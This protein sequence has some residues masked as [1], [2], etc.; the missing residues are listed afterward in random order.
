MKR[1]NLFYCALF[2]ALFSVCR[3]NA[4]TAVYLFEDFESGTM[5][6]GWSNSG[7]NA[8]YDS[9]RW[10]VAQGDSYN[11][12]Y[13]GNYCMR[14][15]SNST[16][17]GTTSVL[18]SPSVLISYSN[19]VVSFYVR[20]EYGG[21]LKVY[22][23]TDSGRTYLS[24]PLDTNLTQIMGWQKKTYS[25]DQYVGQSV[26]VVFVSESNNSGNY[27]GG[28][29]DIDDFKMYEVPACRKVKDIQ[30]LEATT[31]S[32]TLMWSLDDEGLNIPSSFEFDFEDVSTGYNITNIMSTQGETYG[33]FTM[34]NLES[35]VTYRVSAVGNCFTNG[36]SERS[37]YYYFK[38]ACGRAYLPVKYNFDDLDSLNQIC[39]DVVS[40]DESNILDSTIYYGASGKS[41]RLTSNNSNTVLFASDK[42][43]NSNNSILADFMI[44]GSQANMQYSVG[45]IT[46]INDLSTFEALYSGTIYQSNTWENKH[47][48]LTTSRYSVY[49][50]RLCIMH[51][52]G[53]DYINLDSVLVSYVPSCKRPDTLIVNSIDSV[54][55]T[56]SWYDR[57]TPSQYQVECVNTNDNI[58]SSSI[59][60]SNPGIVNNL[61]P[62]TN[63]RFRVRAICAQGDTSVWS[64][65]VS[66]TT[67]CGYAQLP[68]F[69]NFTD[70][71]S[72]PECWST[73]RTATAP[74]TYYAGWEI[75]NYYGIDSYCVKSPSSSNGNRY[76]LTLPAVYIPT[77]NSYELDFWF[78][79]LEGSK[80]GDCVRIYVNDK[81]SLDG[82]TFIDSVHHYTNNYPVETEGEKYYEYYFTIPMSGT[83]YVMIES[84]HRNWGG[85][86]FIDNISVAPVVT[87]RNKV[88]NVALNHNEDNDSIL[89]S[90]QT[91]GAEQQWLVS[92]AVKDLAQDT[93]AYQVQNIVVNDSVWS[94]DV[95]GLLSTSTRYKLTIDV[96]AICSAGDTSDV[97]SFDFEFI[98]KCGATSMPFYEGF[99]NSSSIPTC[100]SLGGNA[101]WSY[102]SDSWSASKYVG[103]GCLKMQWGYYTAYLSTPVFEFEAGK[104]Y[105]ISFSIYRSSSSYAT[106]N[107]GVHLWVGPNANDVTDAEELGFISIKRSVEPAVSS[108]GV[109]EYSFVYSPDTTDLRYVIFQSFG[110]NGEHIYLD[111]IKVIKLPDCM[112]IEQDDIRLTANYTSISANVEGNNKMLEIAVLPDSVST[113]D[114]LSLAITGTS[115]VNDTINTAIANNLTSGT[116]YNVFVRVLC[117]TAEDKISEWV[118]PVACNTKC[119]P[120]VVDSANSYIEDFEHI[121]YDLKY[122]CLNINASGWVTLSGIVTYYSTE[123]IVN[124]GDT[125]WIPESHYTNGISIM[126]SVICDA[127][128]EVTLKAGVNYEFSVM[129]ESNLNGADKVTSILY[130]VNLATNDTIY[131]DRYNTFEGDYWI[132]RTAVFSVPSDGDYSVGVIMDNLQ[133]NHYCYIDNYSLRVL[134]CE[135]P[136]KLEIKNVSAHS[137]DLGII[138]NSSQWEV[139]LC[140]DK[141]YIGIEDF[142]YVV[143]DTVTN[144]TFTI[145]G[146]QANSTYY[147]LARSLCSDSRSYWTQLQEFTTFCDDMQVP[148]ETSFEEGEENGCWRDTHADNSIFNVDNSKSFFGTNSIKVRDNIVIMPSMDVTSLDVMTLSGWVYVEGVDSATFAIGVMNN[149]YDITTFEEVSTVQITNQNRWTEFS[150]AFDILSTENYADVLFAKNIA[151]VCSNSTTYYFD[152][153]TVAPIATCI[154]PRSVTANVLDA[155][156]IAVDI[157][158]NSAN[159]WK[160]S[161]CR[162]NYQNYE[163]IDDTVVN[164]TNV[165]IEALEPQTSYFFAV[166]SICS[167]NDT[168]FEVFTDV[169]TTPCAV[170]SLPYTANFANSADKQ[171]WSSHSNFD[172]D[173]YDYGK[174]Y[175]LRNYYLNSTDSAFLIT[176][177]FRLNTYNGVRLFTTGYCRGDNA[178]GRLRYTLDGGETYQYLAESA[179]S[180]SYG[181]S[182]EVVINNLQPGVVQFEYVVA[183]GDATS[184]YVYGITIEELDTCT[185][186][187]NCTFNNV[188]NN[189]TVSVNIVDTVSTHTQ[190]QY[191]YDTK[192]INPNEYTPILTD[193]AV[194][195]LSNLDFVRHYFYVRSFVN[196]QT[197]VWQEYSFDV[198]TTAFISEI[199]TFV[200]PGLGYADEHFT[201]PSSS[202]VVGD[203]VS[204]AHMQLDTVG[205][206][207]TLF[208]VNIYVPKN[209]RVVFFDTICAGDVYNA[210][211][212]ANVTTTSRL[213]NHDISIYGC[214]SVTLLYLTVLDSTE[215]KSVTICEG[216][217]YHFGSQEITESGVYYDTI[218]NAHGCA[219]AQTL[220]VNV[221]E[222]EYESTA[223][224]CEGGT[225]Y[226]KGKTYSTPGRYEYTMRNVNGCDSV[227]VLN[228][229]AIATRDTIYAE[230]CNSIGFY[231]GDNWILTQGV[232]YDTLQNSIGCDS[233]VTLIL[234][235][236]ETPV[237]HVDDVICESANGSYVDFGF[238]VENIVSDTT[239]RR[240]VIKYDG[241]DSI[242]EVSLQWI[243]TD[244][245]FFSIT[246]KEDEVY[247]FGNNTYNKPGEYVYRTYD[248]YGC[249]SVNIL[250]LTLSTAT[251]NTYALPVVVAPNPVLGG[252]TTY[253]TREWTAEEQ[254]GMQ[255]EVLNA[256]GQLIISFAP[257][258]YPIEV[259]G[260]N[261]SGIYYIRITSGTGDVYIG[262]LIVK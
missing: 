27:N 125:M 17:L 167:A 105:Q 141:P 54:S 57:D 42:I 151:I 187:M 66:A 59:V 117:D 248:E 185:P 240:S 99:E 109:Y 144:N 131:L 256:V 226:W 139:R 193:I 58:V 115:D 253:V 225:Y 89:V 166:A 150:V 262:R 101:S 162:G 259:G 202:L 198:S 123:M 116:S 104:N 197:S 195:N 107:E 3:I 175:G 70:L 170:K 165:V 156:S 126:P 147:C 33:S 254:T 231:F 246:I 32:L 186:P 216:D 258:T 207:D 41:I 75:E 227:L 192:R 247:E 83:V 229:E 213:E 118:G 96:R 114:D 12:A 221:I 74:W 204:F 134:T 85:S 153:I 110:D 102:F 201:I 188:D 94:A 64:W 49:N 244:T 72:L 239:L 241:C 143:A 40:Y 171:C 51:S 30:L 80:E 146:L 243:P 92:A 242:V 22:L 24:N 138:G 53:N 11:N 208:K 212:F 15:N 200:C 206:N 97:K 13:S 224:F 255:V 121:N 20:N 36:W 252:Q 168:S 260:L 113:I 132:R 190:W 7:G 84:D 199:D 251:D 44:R 55:A 129:M 37:N 4:Q 203:T 130:Y 29:H 177:E 31:E 158:D 174:Y 28:Y 60:N 164:A 10:N 178:F 245:V 142:E 145:S 182:K 149:P 39:V 122:S 82:A 217:V 78:K 19:S 181:G 257:T 152:N 172:D 56:L 81:P 183:G 189:G 90:W 222:R 69:E 235:Y 120:F 205:D 63:Y 67:T 154:K 100:W 215:S 220:T 219:V 6:T 237:Y 176:P 34:N 196:G 71:S 250:T 214:D 155:Y 38:T 249:D 135:T 61:T 157:N 65:P 211:G 128:R 148:Y 108:D 111:E 194:F 21:P 218:V 179:L 230:V 73:T 1:I 209:E 18:T 9:Y 25:L 161:V 16:S 79:R 88:Y 140:K 35:S 62:N 119:M 93:I 169:V 14:F 228:L 68:L 232:Y 95:S 234:G 46:N 2:L 180:P 233:I 136:D 87:C 5:P 124:D 103:S 238:N 98:T 223:Y 173:W 236:I 184:Y 127:A 91:K 163:V 160:I 50:T 261:V 210:H 47:L 106:S 133:S 86:M 26:C 48:Y 191:V 76:L 45:L 8:A 159:A 77:S 52:S 23:S 43:E 112:P 137:V